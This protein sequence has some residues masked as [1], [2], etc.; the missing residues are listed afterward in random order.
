[1]RELKYAVR[2]TEDDGGYVVT[3]R[4]LPEAITQGDTV[5]EALSQASDCLEEAIAG[6]IDDDRHVPAP[7]APVRG[8][9]MVSVPAAMALKAAVYLGARG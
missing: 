3:C 8:E 2:L 5:D 1:M 9:H 6:R 4:D 7:S